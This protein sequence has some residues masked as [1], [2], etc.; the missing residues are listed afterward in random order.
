[1]RGIGGW[2]LRVLRELHVIFLRV[3]R[4]IWFGV[5][6][7]FTPHQEDG[8]QPLNRIPLLPHHSA[9]THARGQL[10][11]GVEMVGSNSMAMGE[12]LPWEDIY[13]ESLEDSS[14][15]FGRLDD[16]KKTRT[17]ILCQIPSGLLRTGNDDPYGMPRLGCGCFYITDC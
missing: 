13:L 3:L 5:C 9:H 10:G 16:M 14:S 8:A 2:V 12:E 15:V 17:I 4:K 7:V 11:D 6:S 1:M